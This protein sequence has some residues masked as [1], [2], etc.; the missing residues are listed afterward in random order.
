MLLGL[1]ALSFVIGIIGPLAGVGGGVLF[2]PIIMGFTNLDP[3]FVR[4]CG[5]AIACYSSIM[6][7]ITF[8][9]QRI[10]PFR[11]ILLCSVVL[12]PGAL[13]GAQMGIYVAALG[14][15]GK[16]LVR[17]SLGVLMFLVVLLLSLKRVDWPPARCDSR[18]VKIFKLEY[19][20]FEKT[21]NKEITYCPAR[22]GATLAL[23][24]PVGFCSGFFGLG[25]A[26]AM[27]PV[28]NLVALMPLKVVAATS[29]GSLAFADTGALWVYT[30]SGKV[31]P[32]L[33]ITCALAV[34]LGAR[35]GAKLLLIAKV[36]FVRYLIL[37][38]MIFGGIQLIVRG[39][40][41]MGIIPYRLF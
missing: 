30:Y 34:I 20:Y 5:L 4:A 15:W 33:Y 18:L 3:D 16:G 6:A 31:Y 14:T 38:I 22:I 35:L 26:W 28:Y 29:S 12:L 19:T 23:L 17:A 32:P 2:T 21:L 9:R 7:S 1:F 10:A 40:Y 37:S 24:F 41:E 13:V 25:A 8:F 27:I 36:K 11:F 39:L